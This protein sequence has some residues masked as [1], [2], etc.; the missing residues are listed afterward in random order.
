MAGLLVGGWIRTDTKFSEGAVG[1]ESSGSVSSGKSTG[2][3]GDPGV[4][5]GGLIIDAQLDV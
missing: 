1:C 5:T 4:S 2:G 3:S